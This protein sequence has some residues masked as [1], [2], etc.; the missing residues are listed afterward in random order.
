MFTICSVYSVY[1][2]VQ[3]VFVFAECL[4]FTAMV[5]LQCLPC[6]VSYYCLMHIIYRRC[7]DYLLTFFQTGFIIYNVYAHIMYY[8]HTVFIL[9][10]FAVSVKVNLLSSQLYTRILYTRDVITSTFAK[11]KRKQGTHI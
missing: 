7:T 10:V 2:L 11:S 4:V 3:T 9:V 8:L 1:C 6:S 5:Y